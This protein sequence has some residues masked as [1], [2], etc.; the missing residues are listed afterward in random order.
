M[1]EKADVRVGLQAK[2]A[3]LQERSNQLMRVLAQVRKRYLSPLSPVSYLTY[4]SFDISEKKYR[5][6]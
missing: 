4:R 2:F 1:K 5:T 6:E 3:S